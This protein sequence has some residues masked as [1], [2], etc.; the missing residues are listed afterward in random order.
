MKDMEIV[1]PEQFKDFLNDI[2]GEDA[3]E[4]V[5]KLKQI[6]EKMI[7]QQKDNYKKGIKEKIIEEKDK[8]ILMKKDF[9]EYLFFLVSHD[10]D[11]VGVF[12]TNNK[13]VL[14]KKE[15]L[16]S[17]YGKRIKI[18]D[19]KEMPQ[20]MKEDMEKTKREEKR[21]TSYIG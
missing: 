1:T 12:L 15:Y 19:V 11:D 20:L 9:A 14:E 10:L 17:K 5:N 18:A 16:N 6:K 8:D 21:D 4:I 13:M 7:G 3:K 2:S